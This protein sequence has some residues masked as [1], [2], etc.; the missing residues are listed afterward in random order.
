MAYRAWG[1]GPAERTVV[2][3]H[4]LTGTGRD[5]DV[6][7]VTLA[8][9]GHHVVCPDIVGRGSSDRL[10]DPEDYRLGQYAADMRRLLEHLGTSAVDWIGTSLG[11]LVGMALAAAP[12]RLVRRLVVNDIGPFVPAAA[13][14]RLAVHLGTDPVFED[15][16]AAERWLREVRAPFGALTS[17]QWR[18]MAER[19]VRRDET[20]GYRLHYDPRIAAPFRRAAGSDVDLWSMW[21]RVTCPVLVLR[22][23]RSDLLLAETAAEM[24]VRGPGAEVVEVPGCGH[25]PALLEP[26]Q[27]E[28]IVRW[29]VSG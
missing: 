17:G 16:A 22:G 7:A 13:L 20:G 23:E 28:P 4:G 1:D 10:A 26:G 6:L 24:A 8:G 11:G 14:L 12:E 5:F 25:A 15:L 21:D 19:S 27:I 29:L 3:V 18:R 9:R 2:C